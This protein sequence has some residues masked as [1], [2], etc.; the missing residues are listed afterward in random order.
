MITII[1]VIIVL[2]CL[3]N[4]SEKANKGMAQRL[5]HLVEIGRLS[6]DD[7][8]FATGNI[9]AEQ[10][11]QSTASQS[12]ASQSIA[13]QNTSQQSM[14]EQTVSSSSQ[15][16][17]AQSAFAPQ[18][19]DVVCIL[20]VGQ[21]QPSYIKVQE[22]N[23]Q[24][25]ASVKSVV[26]NK[27]PEGYYG[28]AAQSSDIRSAEEKAIPAKPVQSAP[29][30][31]KQKTGDDRGVSTINI[32][33]VI[34]TLFVILS[35]L[36]FATT[37]W[38]ALNNGIRS[39]IILALTAIFYAASTAAEK[40]FK[41]DRT[42]VA[43]FTL[44]SVF[45]P[46][47]L[48]A[49]GFFKLFGE[50]FSFFGEGR[51]LLLGIIFA[52]LFGTMAA[53]A[54]K[55]RIKPLALLSL[56]SMSASVASFALAIN[57]FG[58]VFSL[59]IA[60][61][62]AVIT[63]CG[64]F[65]RRIQNERLSI[66]VPQW[67]IFSCVNLTVL[68]LM[69]IIFSGSGVLACICSAL[70]ALL[71]L[72]RRITS[73]ENGYGLIPFAVLS[74]AAAY[75]LIVPQDAS[76]FLF[77]FTVVS[78]AVFAAGLAGGYT[79]RTKKICLGISICTMSVSLLL[80]ID[81]I[82]N[83]T[84]TFPL[85]IAVAIMLGIS[86][87]YV[88]AEKIKPAGIM[89]ALLSAYLFYGIAALAGIGTEYIPLFVSTLVLI[90]F[91]V[92]F[93]IKKL[94]L[95]SAY[96][97]SVFCFG[98]S[99]M[100]LIVTVN[101]SFAD[102]N[103]AHPLVSVGI[104]LETAAVL[105]AVVFEK[106]DTVVGRICDWI[107]PFDIVLISIPAYNMFAYNSAGGRIFSLVCIMLVYLSASAAF[108]FRDKHELS[109]RL[110]APFSVA[111]LLSCFMM[112]LFSIEFELPIGY[113]VTYSVAFAAMFVL[114]SLL[115]KSDAARIAFA[116]LS[117]VGAFLPLITILLSLQ[118]TNASEEMIY[119][120]WYVAVYAIW[121]ACRLSSLKTKRASALAAAYAVLAII[122]GIFGCFDNMYTCIYIPAIWSVFFL[123]S[124][125]KEKSVFRTFARYTA[126]FAGM[127]AVIHILINTT[128]LD[129]KA[130]FVVWFLLFAVF[131]LAAD[132][133]SK[134]YSRFEG[135][136]TVTYAYTI[137]AALVASVASLGDA[138]SGLTDNRIFII[139]MWSAAILTGIRILRGEKTRS[140]FYLLA[141][142][143]IF[144]V[145][146]TSGLI[147]CGHNIVYAFYATFACACA[148]AFFIA[149]AENFSM[150]NELRDYFSIALWVLT[151]FIMLVNFIE[152]PDNP[153][154]TFAVILAVAAS[155]AYSY[156]DSESNLMALPA[157]IILAPYI[158]YACNYYDISSEIA[159]LIMFILFAASGRLVHKR[160]CVKND[161]SII[162]DWLSI[163][164]VLPALMISAD[165][166]TA[167]WRFA[168][169]VLLAG[170]PMLFYKRIGQEE[171]ACRI[172]LSVTAALSCITWWMQPFEMPEII[173]L[174]FNYLPLFLLC[175]VLWKIWH[176]YRPSFETVGFVTAIIAIL[177]MSFD[178]VSNEHLADSLMLIVGVIGMLLVSFAIKKRRWFI[179][180]VVTLL[181]I[182]LCMT[183]DFW[184]SLA[185]WAYL[186][187][188][189]ILLIVIAAANELGKQ[190]LSSDESSTKEKIR[191]FME[192][193]TW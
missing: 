73:R 3:L 149:S 110:C 60:L 16:S 26:R 81:S 48:V 116:V 192:E 35:G 130:G 33:L 74:A 91:A 185:W 114:Y 160:I 41:L 100:A 47:T 86:V 137:L 44:G 161:N 112:S 142:V 83:V 84:F 191:R 184:Q 28:S 134:K 79:E 55:Y 173:S 138:V 121:I 170:Y 45:M 157:V 30:P 7:Y 27:A 76:G 154:G 43:F 25:I 141:T 113:V 174:E 164:A 36:I 123:I 96:T 80:C 14:P 108:V 32:V 163:S 165:G 20:P 51:Y 104:L 155:Y 183:K 70:S 90:L 5:S 34:G 31:V 120:V 82:I 1:V 53:G 101:N 97:D 69:G 127:G 107:L 77:V 180:A 22:K 49:A 178:A 172:I 167:G 2:A 147:F 89:F 38:Q 133:L 126:P 85:L 71:F 93:F 176:E 19:D 151:L 187:I 145:L 146:D 168:G 193:W 66:F 128:S 4:K 10:A 153:F 131:S 179:L 87:Y 39:V 171:K 105:A 54:I 115:A 88:I 186:L 98:L 42:S 59:V 177:H 106:N 109:E 182:T 12:M 9:V 56:C 136:S 162:I 150:K 99:L 24:D 68:S 152:I 37:T 140:N 156:A 190:K 92:L 148:A 61:Y 103:S 118:M 75:K 11:F 125:K 40:K 122:T 52:V 78:A 63:V 129:G 181:G 50:W 95:R 72:D 188:V 13:P 158:T 144:A 189:G 23:T 159:N 124:L 94:P 46:T 58:D 166:D 119:L 135:F 17:P 132:F 57:G 15:T 64:I 62:S 21:E 139:V 29:T 143:M 175:F 117:A 111:A 65:V 67:G 8:A 102:I 6:K 18:S 169:T